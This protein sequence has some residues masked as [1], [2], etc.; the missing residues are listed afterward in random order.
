M[1]GRLM[2]ATNLS[3]RF[4]EQAGK[5]R[6]A[7]LEKLRIGALKVIRYN[8]RLKSLSKEELFR[9]FDKDGDGEIDEEEFV[10]FFEEAEKELK[11][12][13]FRESRPADAEAAEESG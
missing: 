2:R 13:D 1:D 11:D 8:Q 10:A 3:S 5:K 12:L 9:A 4:R 7:E 6:G